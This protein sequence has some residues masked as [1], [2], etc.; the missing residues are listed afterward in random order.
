[1]K[2]NLKISEREKGNLPIEVSK[3]EKEAAESVSMEEQEEWN[4]V[5]PYWNK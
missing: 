4:N 5:L 3:E 2:E 1:M